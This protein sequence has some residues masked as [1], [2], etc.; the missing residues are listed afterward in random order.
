[1]VAA[2][3]VRCKVPR[4]VLQE[5]LCFGRPAPPSM[6]SMGGGEEPCHNLSSGGRSGAAAGNSLRP[7]VC[8]SELSRIFLALVQHVSSVMYELGGVCLQ[9]ALFCICVSLPRSQRGFIN[10]M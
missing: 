6:G 1:M 5:R 4:R 9:P 7:V 2:L 10:Q 3:S 8:I